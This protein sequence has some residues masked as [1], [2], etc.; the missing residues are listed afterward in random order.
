MAAT[1]ATFFRA[2]A[3]LMLLLGLTAFGS[4]LPLGRWSLP[5]ALA[6][7]TAKLAIVFLVFMQ[8]RYR[9]GL[10]R[11][12]AAAGFFWLAIAGLLTLSDY[13]TRNWLF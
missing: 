13:F 5:F 2:Y 10:V 6:I 12:F 4:Q 9:R 3:A 1:R 11:I 8:L 7:A